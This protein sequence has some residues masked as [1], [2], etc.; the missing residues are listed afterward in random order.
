[1]IKKA[2]LVVNSA[3]LLGCNTML[4]GS[5]GEDNQTLEAFTQRVENVFKLQNSMTNAVMLMEVEP[6]DVILEAEKAMHTAC[7]PLNEYASREMEGLSSD[8]ALQKQVEQTAVSCE[9]A[10]KQ[11][12]SLLS[13]TK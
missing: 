9:R 10:A 11:L 7:K 1:M 3:L 4:L 13:L 2:F 12:Q 5:Y 8:F 6:S